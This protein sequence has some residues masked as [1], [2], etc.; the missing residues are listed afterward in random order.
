MELGYYIFQEML[1]VPYLFKFTS[2]Q[3]AVPVWTHSV[4][5]NEKMPKVGFSSPKDRLKIIC[6]DKKTF[7]NVIKVMA[8]Y[9]SF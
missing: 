9:S 8:V 3:V 1:Y 4:L 2:L 7:V 5:Y 6:G